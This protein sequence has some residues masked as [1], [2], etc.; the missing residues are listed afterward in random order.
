VFKTIVDGY[1]WEFCQIQYN[2]IDHS[3]RPHG[4]AALRRRRRIGV[5]VME[6]LRGG[7][8]AA[9]QPEDVQRIWARSPGRTP[10]DWAL[11]WVGTIPRW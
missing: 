4:R 7:T 3:T 8:L 9:T 6:P 11:R 2:F 10:A 1:D 5:I